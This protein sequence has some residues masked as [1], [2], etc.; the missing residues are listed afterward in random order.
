[1]R[2]RHYNDSLLADYSKF[3]ADTGIKKFYSYGIPCDLSE[4]YEF[5]SLVELENPRFPNPMKNMIMVDGLGYWATSWDYLDK[6]QNPGPGPDSRLR[7]VSY[8]TDF[9][10]ALILLRFLSYGDAVEIVESKPELLARWQ[11]LW[12]RFSGPGICLLVGDVKPQTDDICEFPLKFIG[13]NR[14]EIL[15][16]AI[17]LQNLK[18]YMRAWHFAECTPLLVPHHGY[19]DF[20]RFK[21][22]FEYEGL[23]DEFGRAIEKEPDADDEPRG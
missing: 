21:P 9:T 1:M 5:L 20:L 4:I 13:Q 12:D 17:K 3:W 14:N 22:I 7:H 23:V 16:R 15:T 19:S 18:S 11:A 10:A 6:L 8:C 2:Q